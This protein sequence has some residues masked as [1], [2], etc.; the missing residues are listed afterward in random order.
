MPLPVE[1]VRLTDEFLACVD[2]GAPGLVTD[3]YLHGSLC[4]GEFFDGSDLD[5]VAVLG[6]TPDVEALAALARA[7]ERVREEFPGRRYEGFHCRRSD[8]EGPPH[9]V[10]RVPVHYQGAFDPDGDLDVN[11]VTWHELAERGL[12]VR[13]AL[14]AVHTDLEALL[15]FTR[16]NL[17]TY[18][19]STLAQIDTAIDE[20]GP[21]AVGGE[22]G[23][24][25]WVTLGAARLH[26]LLA[27]RE[28]TSKSGAGRYVL[29]SLDARWHPLAVDALAIREQPGSPSSYDDLGQRGLDVRDFLS[30]AVEDGPRTSW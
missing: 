1:V 26:H 27:R 22:D 8:L 2:D 20:H 6:R 30:W 3:L 19:R 16:D 29:D 9:A 21:P 10:A 25:A 17:D 5:F 14:P 24:V 23:T 4:W 28:L 13:G 18:W 12:V 7:H 11:P 15:A